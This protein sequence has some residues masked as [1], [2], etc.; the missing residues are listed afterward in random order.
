MVFDKDGVLV[1]SEPIKLAALEELF[2]DFPASFEAIRAFNRANIGMPRREKLEHFF[3]QII[4][5]PDTEARVEE[6]LDRAYWHM[7]ATLMRAPATPGL[8]DFIRSSTHPKYVCSVAVRE[9]VEDQMEALGLRDAF[10]GL[11]A[12]PER[13]ADVL[14]ALSQSHEDPVLFWGD[15]MRDY[16]AAQ[17]A[18]VAFI[19]VCLDP[20]RQAFGDLAVP[21]IVD[22]TDQDALH[23]AM[24][25][26]LAAQGQAAS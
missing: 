3:G 4:Q 24:W 11:F 2:L 18:G 8:I 12:Y 15:T 23:R 22:F 17:E 10:A 19:G 14:R 20:E 1:D 21:V 9:E 7:R 26:A 5:A 16:Q 6:Y 13:K 25:A